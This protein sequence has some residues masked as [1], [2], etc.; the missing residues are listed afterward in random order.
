M[1]M[2]AIPVAQERVKG[3]CNPVA[4]PLPSAEADDVACLFKALGDP[5]RVQML[6]MLKAATAP[7]CVCD[8]TAAFDLEQPTI[9]HH[10]ARLRDAGLISSS[11]QGIW[12]FYEL[13]ADLTAGARAALASIR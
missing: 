2:S 8:F 6:H 12:S 5:T 3:C 1:T 11:K 7:I 9:S 10:L 13:R 4:E